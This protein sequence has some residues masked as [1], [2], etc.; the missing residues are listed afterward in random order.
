[1][2]T[3]I[4][5][6][7]LKTAVM[8][9]FRFKK[10][11]ICADEVFNADVLVDTGKEI[12]EIEC[13]ISKSDLKA[14]LKKPK[15]NEFKDPSKRKYCIPNKFYICVPTELVE[16]AK[17]WTEE[18]NQAYGV[19][20]LSNT[21]Y[22]HWVKYTMGWENMLY[23]SKKAKSLHKE[24]YSK[25]ERIALRLSSKLINASIEGLRYE[26][27]KEKNSSTQ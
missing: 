2:G 24:Y 1:M 17:K 19:I 22:E 3:I 11:F 12:I 10:T 23:F 15:H 27:L 7:H 21:K 26:R 18:V 4:H 6:G 14:D 8:A 13:K 25:S 5:S 9:Y 20:E 16:K